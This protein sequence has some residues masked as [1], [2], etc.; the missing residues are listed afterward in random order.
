MKD[1]CCLWRTI[2]THAFDEAPPLLTVLASENI[3]FILLF[4]KQ[5]KFIGFK[6]PEKE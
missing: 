1:C 5:A 4:T 2:D 6:S 3:L